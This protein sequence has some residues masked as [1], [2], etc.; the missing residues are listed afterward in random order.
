ML[1]NWYSL[2][3]VSGKVNA[4]Q[5]ET[6]AK[7]RTYRKGTDISMAILDHGSD[8]SGTEIIGAGGIFFPLPSRWQISHDLQKCVTSFSMRG[9]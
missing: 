3:V 2:W 4:C 7:F 6:I 1:L 8:M 5:N 9:Q